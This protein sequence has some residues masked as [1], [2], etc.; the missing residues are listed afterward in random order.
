MLLFYLEFEQISIKIIQMLKSKT[1]VYKN[2]VFFLS[3][4]AIWTKNLRYAIL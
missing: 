1:L 3:K 2:T 4:L